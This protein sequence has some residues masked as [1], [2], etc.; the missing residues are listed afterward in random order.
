MA[1]ALAA[2]RQGEVTVP[3]DDTPRGLRLRTV[4]A[5]ERAASRAA[6]DE[7]GR[8][9]I[10]PTDREAWNRLAGAALALSATLRLPPQQAASSV[11]NQRLD[12]RWRDQLMADIAGPP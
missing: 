9:L 6:C 1:A 5:D 12:P 4:A 10:G 8:H 2:A 7:N 3:D 11:L